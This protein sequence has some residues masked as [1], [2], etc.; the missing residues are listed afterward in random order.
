M[1]R[2]GWHQRLGKKRRR[3]YGA[4]Y[5]SYHGRIGLKAPALK[6]ARRSF[7]DAAVKAC[8]HASMEAT[9]NAQNKP[10]ESLHPLQFIA[11]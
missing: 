11:E 6:S 10:L 8:G 4:I 7:D 3:T 5:P 9:D 1:T 2:G